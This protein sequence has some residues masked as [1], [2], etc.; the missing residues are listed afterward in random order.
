MCVSVSEEKKCEST[1]HSYE[2]MQR[3]CLIV[4]NVCGPFSNVWEIIFKLKVNICISI[5]LPL[6]FK[7]R[8]GCDWVSVQK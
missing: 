1:S 5:K 3:C 6:T 4:N 8:T 2:Y 7:I